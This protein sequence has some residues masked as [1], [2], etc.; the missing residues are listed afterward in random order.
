MY[1][2]AYHSSSGKLRRWYVSTEVEDS[3]RHSIQLFC[4]ANEKI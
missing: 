2:L 3:L 1:L 4:I